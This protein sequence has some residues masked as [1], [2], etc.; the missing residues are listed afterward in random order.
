MGFHV[1]GP[2]AGEVR[3]QAGGD[4]VVQRDSRRHQNRVA[5]PACTR[6]GWRRVYWREPTMRRLLRA[7]PLT[8]LAATLLCAVAVRGQDGPP[9][10]AEVAPLLERASAAPGATVRA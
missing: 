1:P 7:T 2:A 6:A 10:R 8:V 9:P 5:G 3:R 4:V